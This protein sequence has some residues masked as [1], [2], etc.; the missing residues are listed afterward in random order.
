MRILLATTG[1]ATVLTLA[2][3]TASAQTRTIDEEVTT[4]VATATAASGQPADVEITED[5]AI[6]LDGGTAVTLDSANDVAN[7][8]EIQITDADGAVGIEASTAGSGD[9]TNSGSIV[10]DESYEAE[11]ADDDDDL[12]GP[13]AEG[14]GRFGIRTDGAFTGDIANSGTITV[15]GNDSGGIALG[16]A[17]AG[18]LSSTGK[19]ELTGDDGAAIQAGDVTG[20]VDLRGTIA[21]RGENTVGV[22]LDGDVG[23]AV[24]VQGSIASTG[25]RYLQAPGD[26]EDLDTDDL[27]QGGPA[28]RV[29]GN[30][31]GGILVDAPPADADEDV[32]DEDDDGIDD[33]DEGTGSITSY[34][35]APALQ[36]GSDARDLT[37]G[38]VAGADGHSLVIR[39][40]VGS[41]G[42]YSGVDAVAIE[43][44]GM[45]HAVDLGEGI[46]ID[47]AVASQGQASATA[48]RLADGA[49]ANEIL[50][51]G[52]VS[53]R[54][55]SDEAHV[56]RAIEIGEGATVATI[57][58][59][60]Q[61]S[62]TTGGAGTAIAIE[63]RSGTLD[64]IENSGAIAATGATDTN[65][66]MIA[67][68]LSAN[69]GGA[70]I[71]QSL[72]GEDA[73][74]PAIRGDI[75]F[76]AGDDMLEVADGAVGGDV[77]FGAGGNRYLLSGDAAHSGAIAF[78][79]G[80][81]T[82]AL[83]DEA[84]VVGNVDF[85]GGADVLTLAEGTAFRGALSGSAG[86]A[87]SVSG[88]L[89]ATNAG[90]VALGSLDVGENGALGVT[91][92]G[93]TGTNTVYQVAGAASF[94][95]G[96][97]V[98][99]HLDTIQGSLGDH[100][101]VEA[102]TL[103][104][105]DALTT[106]EAVLPFLFKSDLTADEAAGTV[107]LSIDR[108]SA[109][110]LGMNRSEA[111]AYD[112]VV[113]A[114][115]AD[116]QIADTFLA[117]D[118]ADTFYDYYRTFLP[119]DAAGLFESVTQ[120][121]RQ[122]ARFLS[123]R[124]PESAQE[125][126]NIWLQQY[127]W[128]ASKD[129]GETQ[130]YDIGGW[131]ATGG[132]EH[133]IGNLGYLGVTLGF[134]LGRDGDGSN[135]N[136][137]TTG[138]YEAAV[139]WRARFGGLGLAAR[140]SIGKVDFHSQ[141]R[142]FGDGFDRLSE[143]DWGGTLW[144]ATGMASYDL[145]VGKRLHI[146]PR[147]AIDYYRLSEDA[148]SETGGGDAFDLTVEKRVSDEAA[149]TGSMTLGYEL[150]SLDPTESWLRLELEGGRREIVGGNIAATTARY[151]DG[152]P[153]TLQPTARKSGWL[154]RVRLAGGQDLFTVGGEV[155]AEEQQDHTAIAARMSVRLNW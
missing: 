69:D 147:A 62:A 130:A 38:G 36:I 154:G 140:G 46:A 41:A 151:G 109:G 74:A 6:T 59:S 65:G 5:G 131:G 83:S 118:D 81:D 10:I 51:G 2:P 7:A 110:E 58:N 112:A 149:A 31:G 32:D 141:R 115:D 102:G 101:I 39:G 95:E 121:S 17:L 128:G 21:T 80:A 66:R 24:H 27:L 33:A 44:G 132:A 11:D 152:D 19:I 79:S 122:Q 98:L 87:A 107:T 54:G 155:S 146:R 47:G 70:T 20:D 14:T 139:H 136:E 93:E 90:A 127:G 88:T 45:G 148:H 75:L 89:D 116:E 23:G 50:V 97:R 71:R 72:A 91:I 133:A 63:D 49:A 78:G 103:S 82:L 16:G 153:F 126:W 73:A 34:G 119:A 48:L 123:D 43:I 4:P 125:K 113:N 22:A 29:A 143:G 67:I 9:I 76:G 134:G 55:G 3:A 52:E 12:D 13:F 145:A 124:Q 86:L 85:G 40:S 60:G 135:D 77:A 129:V 15:E 144:S 120:A 84:S 111:G 1:L 61:I 96:A 94:A 142:F 42:V 26:V 137:V 150:G 106:S 108:K 53:A 92:D 56:T 8:G 37:I 100:V 114:L 99:V 30:V 64:L 28:V 57:S 138:Q 105:G 117:V 25:Y 104:G 18:S 68:D 35:A